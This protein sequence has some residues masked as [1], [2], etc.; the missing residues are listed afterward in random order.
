VKCA[1]RTTI[2][3]NTGVAMSRSS[4]RVVEM[5]GR[6]AVLVSDE[7]R[8]EVDV[9]D[10][11]VRVGDLIVADGARVDVVGRS[12]L[13]DP[14]GAERRVL[15]PRRLRAMDVL[16]TVEDGVRAF[17]R[18]RGF[19]EVRTP[20]LVDNPGME[21]H[22]RP[23]RTRGGWLHTSPEFAMKR[24]LAGGLARIFQI[25]RV[26]R[27]E[28]ASRTHRAEFTMLELYRA[29][30]DDEDIQRDVEELVAYLAERV[31]GRPRIGAIDVAPPWPRLR[32]RDLYREH[33]GVDLVADDL[34]AACARLGLAADAGDTWDDLYFRIWLGVVE[35][36]LPQ[37]R[38]VFVTR[39]PASQAAL[40]RVDADADGSRWA[41]RFEVYA[42]GL[43]LGNAF[44]ELTDPD[45]QRRR[46][47][48]DNDLRVRLGEEALPMPETFLRALE[49]G[50]PPAGGIAIG[51]DRLAML[52]AGED[53]IG[54]FRW[55]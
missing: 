2:G 48:A 11:D 24:L 31:A 9:G 20:T 26:F 51:V 3:Y 35:P 38:A 23:F 45:E 43:E 8:H 52:L 22:I 10:A 54:W 44:A 15:H 21:P 41:R 12:R 47:I 16:H 19:R 14:G 46:F 13:P 53:D 6:V 25:C 42:G 33:A 17:L 1:S 27:D 34:R 4:G 5:E 29:W 55:E 32:V 30:A 50:M 36:R 49:D 18:G 39:Y 37:G 7:G 28:P 40:A